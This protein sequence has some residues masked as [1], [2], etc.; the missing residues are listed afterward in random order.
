MPSGVFE[1]AISA[2][3]CQTY[4]LNDTAN[5]ITFMTFVEI[6]YFFA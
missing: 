3:P 5:R 2:E 4:S 6:N 1:P